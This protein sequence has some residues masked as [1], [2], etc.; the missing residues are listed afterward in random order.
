MGISR[1]DDTATDNVVNTDSVIDQNDVVNIDDIVNT[2]SLIDSDGVVNIDD[3]VGTDGVINTD[4]IVDTDGAVD[5]NNIV[6]PD[7]VVDISG[8]NIDDD[9]PEAIDLIKAI[10][11][12]NSGTVT[13]DDML[14]T[15]D[16]IHMPDM[17]D[18][19]RAAMRAAAAASAAASAAHK[20]MDMDDEI[21]AAMRAGTAPPVAPESMVSGDDVEERIGRIFS[22]RYNAP[23]PAA[24]APA[25]P[26]PVFEPEPE[27]IVNGDDVEERLR[28]MFLDE[29]RDTEP[30]LGSGL[31][32]LDDTDAGVGIVAGTGAAVADAVAVPGGV[33]IKGPDERDTPFDLPDHVLTSTLADI[34]YQQGQPQ[35]ALHIYERLAL[36][37]PGDKRLL[38]KIEEIRGVLQQLGEGGT[39]APAEAVRPEKAPSA[40]SG[41][42]KKADDGGTPR[43]DVRPLAGVRIKKSAPAKKG[44]RAKPKP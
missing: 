22:D 34:Y 32:P 24:A 41:R 20:F 38:A 31:D 10:E 16:V 30:P 9:D 28:Q 6:T 17:D 7:G 23:P 36:R 43:S 37:D 14:G 3:V 44:K 5:T 4:G 27:P 13:A 21:R 39:A 12:I 33:E 11:A 18:E 15:G 26:V 25:A 35:L 40:S 1:D 2:D 29:S 19:I 42:K 8:F